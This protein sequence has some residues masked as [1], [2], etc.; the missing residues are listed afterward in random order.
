MR[1][2]SALFSN[3]IQA[4]LTVAALMASG[5]HTE[6][7]SI[8]SSGTEGE[9]TEHATGVAAG[10]G[11]LVGGTAGLLTGLGLMAIPGLGP[12]VAAGWLASTLTGAVSGAAIGGIAGNVCRS[13]IEAGVS[14]TDANIYSAGIEQGGTFLAVRVSDEQYETAEEILEKARSLT[15][16]EINTP[17]APS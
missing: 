10:T 7:I 14:E 4:K 16:T 5:I 3:T 17:P 6:E 2:V 9:L 1:T 12:I 11:A 8:I 15:D 13:L